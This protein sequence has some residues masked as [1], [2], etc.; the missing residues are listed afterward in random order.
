M[1]AVLHLLARDPDVQTAHAV[2]ALR[3]RLGDAAFAVTTRTIGRGGDYAHAAW[4]GPR[5]PA[6][7]GGGSGRALRR[8][9]RVGRTLAG[10]GCAGGGA[11]HR[12]HRPAGAD[13][14][15]VRAPAPAP[16]RTRRAPRLHERGAAPRVPS[17]PP[18]RGAGDRGPV[19][20]R[21]AGDRSPAAAAG[22][23]AR[24]AVRQRLGIGPEDYVL[25]APGES[26][27]AAAHERAAWAGSILHVTDE[28]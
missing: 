5:P 12:L 25:L 10:R 6:R 9:P 4:A 2:A 16:G 11:A 28:R 26:T 13:A 20:P 1:T 15:G 24:R 22:A 7:A 8:R 23:D 17:P 18:P 19:P 3:A 14:G 21:P 27:R